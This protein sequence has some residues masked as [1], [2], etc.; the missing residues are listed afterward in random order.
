VIIVHRRGDAGGSTGPTRGGIHQRNIKLESTEKASVA[1]PPK[2]GDLHAVCA[3]GMFNIFLVVF[4][5]T[6]AFAFL[7]PFYFIGS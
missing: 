5:T 6:L 7:E 1:T 3:E 2:C 4:F